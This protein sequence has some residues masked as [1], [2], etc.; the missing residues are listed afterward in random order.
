MRQDPKFLRFSYKNIVA[1]A[2]PF[3]NNNTAVIKMSLQVLNEQ[4]QNLYVHELLVPEYSS[5]V[6]SLP[7]NEE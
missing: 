4:N 6:S 1:L 2:K 7:F 3:N 5:I